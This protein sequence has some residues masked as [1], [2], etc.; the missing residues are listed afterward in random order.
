MDKEQ[1]P[2]VFNDFWKMKKKLPP[3]EAS[4]IHQENLSKEW[5]EFLLAV[6]R[7]VEKDLQ[8]NDT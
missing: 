8:K 3:T 6:K 2:D 1:L 7:R 4:P 5:N